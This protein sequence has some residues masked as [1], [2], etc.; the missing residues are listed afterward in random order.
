MKNVKPDLEIQ[1][2]G[3]WILAGEHAVLRGGDALVFPLSSRF[4]KL[5]FHQSDDEFEINFDRRGHPELELILWSVLEKAFNKLHLK[6][7]DLKG[8]LEFES[9]IIFGAGMGASATLCVSLTRLFCELGFLKSDEQYD[10]ARDLE[11]LFHGESSGVDVAVTLYNKPLLFSRNHGYQTL[12]NYQKPL[13][14]LSHT[15][16]R[17]V[18]KDCVDQV[19]KLFVTDREK[20]ESIDEKMKKAVKEFKFLLAEKT[21]DHSAWVRTLTHA[22]S[23]F[24][25]WGLVNEAVRIHETQLLKAGAAAVKLTGSGG[26]G[27]MLSYWETPPP[28]DVTFELIPC[29]NE[30]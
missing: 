20:A 18:T 27:F 17:G 19:K 5:N 15:G 11:N 26:G 6:R 24:Y 12:E 16:A 13:L 14:F 8:R 25:D 30:A 1:V 3:K 28:A 7:R 21:I 10:F 9:K 29:F 4:L 23:C 2:C 22:H